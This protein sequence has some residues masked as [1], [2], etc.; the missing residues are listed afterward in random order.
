MVMEQRERE[1]LLLKVTERR[2]D[3]DLVRRPRL[4]D[5]FLRS[6]ISQIEQL[7]ETIDDI[8]FLRIALGVEEERILER[9]QILGPQTKHPLA[10]K[11]Q[12]VGEPL[13][14]GAVR[15]G[16]VTDHKSNER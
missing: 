7:E 6:N 12:F 1:F 14:F 9:K 4:E 15:C 2:C 11:L 10:L 8:D 3:R 13:H 5:K 16:L